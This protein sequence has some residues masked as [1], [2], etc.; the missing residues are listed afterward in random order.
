MK[1][2][3]PVGKM[4]ETVSRSLHLV[5]VVAV[6]TRRRLLLGPLSDYVQFSTGQLDDLVERG[7]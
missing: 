3:K 1:P 2:S 5:E 4:V 7:F 6:I